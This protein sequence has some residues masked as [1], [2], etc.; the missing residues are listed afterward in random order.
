VN[1]RS[2]ALRKPIK[3]QW[4]PEHVDVIVGAGHVKKSA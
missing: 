3:D 1:Q 2:I 4:S